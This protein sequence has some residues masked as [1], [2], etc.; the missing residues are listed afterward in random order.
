MKISKI[1]AAVLS[2]GML[3][4]VAAH[5]ADAPFTTTGSFAITSDYLYRGV[6]QSSN[7]AAVQGSFTLSHESGLYASV[8]GSSIAF[9]NGLELDP[10]IG[11]AGK[12]GEVGYDVGV[13]RYGYPGN[14]DTLPFT[15][16]YGSVSYMGG[17]FGLA[18]S[19]NFFAETGKSLYSYLEYSKEVGGFGV[20]AHVGYNKFDEAALDPVDGYIDYKLGVSKSVG[21]VGFELAYIG[22]DLDDAEC[23]GFGGDPT[24]CEGRVVVTASKSF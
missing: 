1:S 24:L 20:M 22:S 11:F 8:W 9:S 15:E 13:L 6:S 2:V 23:A 21:G 12:A 7:T 16:V 5:A 10:S 17:K 19:D 4:G 14:T 18:Y 3:L